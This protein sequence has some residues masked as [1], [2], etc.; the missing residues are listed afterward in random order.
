[1]TKEEVA[2]QQVEMSSMDD[3]SP[4]LEAD[5][6]AVRSY[7]D[8]PVAHLHAK[9]FL[10]VFAVLTIYFAQL[11]NIVG[12]GAVSHILDRPVP[13]PSLTIELASTRHLGRC[14]RLFSNL[15]AH[16]EHRNHDRCP[17]TPGLPGS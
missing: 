9:T 5:L 4:K 14:W 1:M 15:M 8:E 6:G 3:K 10:G 11:F 17:W 13:Q 7:G 2:A 16:H 12:A